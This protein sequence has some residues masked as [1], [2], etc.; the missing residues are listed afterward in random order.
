MAA[1]FARRGLRRRV[2]T[3]A[4]AGTI[5]A[6][7]LAGC[8]ASD[9]GSGSSDASSGDEPV[10]ITF[11]EAMSSGSLQTALAD[12]TDRF[13]EAN[14]RVTVELVEQPDYGTLQTKIEAEVSAGNAPTI[15]QMYPGWAVPLVEAGALESL[16]D[17]VAGSDEYDGFYEGIKSSMTLED[18]T[19]WMWPFNKSLYVQYYNTDMVSEA[20]TTWDDFGTV[21]RDVSKDGVVALSVDPGG[22]GGMGAGTQLVD[23]LAQSNGGATFDDTGAPTFTDPAV[24][25]ALQ[26]F[27]DMQSDGALATGTNYP[28]QVALGAETGAFDLSTVAGYTYELDA[29]GDKFDLGVAPLPEGSAGAANSL[30]GTNIGMFSSAS[31]AEKDAAWSYM[32]FLTSPAEMG[33]WAAAT[34]YLPISADAM[35]DDS[36]ADYLA[37][38]PWVSGVIEQLDTATEPVPQSWTSEA[39]GYLAAAVSE[40]LAGSAT[41]EDALASAQ[42]SAEALVK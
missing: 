5:A 34:G 16:D 11:M 14:P 33:A 17:R 36:Y 4:G 10:T 22:S 15:A 24:V 42:A 39:Q 6:L 30:S 28:G 8:S 20:P 35:N 37:E 32:E 12:A 31:D 7:A 41:P 23:I 2:L 9:G 19:N 27:V 26:Y 38:N 21:A 18:G 40:A 13:E 25:D 29:V 1:P 3:V